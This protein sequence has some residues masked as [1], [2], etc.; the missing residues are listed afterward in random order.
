MS[1]LFRCSGSRAEHLGV[2]HQRGSGHTFIVSTGLGTAQFD[3]SRLAKARLKAV[4][5][6]VKKI[7][8]ADHRV[9]AARLR[10]VSSSERGKYVLELTIAAP[11]G[12]EAFEI[13]SGVV[14]ASIHAAGGSTAEW[15]KHVVPQLAGGAMR[16]LG[17][18][19]PPSSWAEVTAAAHRHLAA[20]PV[21]PPFDPERAPAMRP[22]PR[23]T[24]VGLIDLR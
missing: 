22:V 17:Q 7:R 4:M 3:N 5:G 10:P 2:T 18:P 16:R 9:R 14:R 6:E 21:L 13:G 12:A 24:A 15:E 20:L 23:P 19:T 8:R 1:K 11:S